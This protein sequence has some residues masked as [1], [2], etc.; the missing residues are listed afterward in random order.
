MAGLLDAL[1]L[2]R[3]VLV[4]PD[5][6]GPIGRLA[7]AERPS[8]SAGILLANTGAAPPSADSRPTPIHRLS[9]LR[10]VSDLLFPGLGFPL[11]SLGLVQGDRGS[12]RGNVNIA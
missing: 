11:R 5:W 7:L 4:G 2:E 3:V 12:I 9:H 6:R 1:G 8:R 10:L